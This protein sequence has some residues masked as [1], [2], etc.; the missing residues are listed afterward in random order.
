MINKLKKK[1]FLIIQISFSSIIV[2]L[3]L[4]FTFVNYRNIINSS[5]FFS[6]KVFPENSIRK[7]RDVTQNIPQNTLQNTNQNANQNEFINIDGIYSFEIKDQRLHFS[8][9]DNYSE[10]ILNYALKVS[11]K[12]NKD[13]I[14][15]NYVYK[16]KKLDNNTYLVTLIENKEMINHIKI[17]IIASITIGIILCF[18]IS[19]VANKISEI[20]VKPVEE[21]FEKQKQFI[22]DASHE[23]KTPLAIIE[24]NTEVLENTNKNNKWIKYIQNEIVSM[25]KLVNDLLI[26]SK[27]ENE[28][29]K[30]NVSNV[31][32]TEEI[33]L[34]ISSFDVVAFENGI[35]INK[36][37]NE[38]IY[39]NC[40]KEEIK[41]IVSILIDNAIKHTD[42]DKNIYINLKEIK[43]EIQLEVI[44]EGEPIP[45]EER[46]K[47]FER[48]YRVDKS[49]NR[50]EKRYGLGL[51]IAKATVEKYKGKIE[52]L[53][54]E[55]YTIFK[56]ELP[57]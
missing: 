16:V 11:K 53:Y 38:N 49:R 3:I 19:F 14:I 47:I 45:E 20:I 56:I 32:L 55:N 7:N 50:S 8:L 15:G 36:E 21:T 22:S 37:I 51:A 5:N 54:E 33:N 39:F 28:T 48:F 24:A 6:E 27:A 10:E 30:A 31:N 41:R 12:D 25:N 4:L 29:I 35:N 18:I 57:N 42:K 9:N 44:N 2:G 23:L 46:E 40:D 17:L 1:I 34:I 52:V 26:L 43:N 13:G